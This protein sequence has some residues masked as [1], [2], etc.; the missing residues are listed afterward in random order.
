MGRELMRIGA[1][2][3]Q[4]EWSALALTEGP[5]RVVQAHR[6]FIEAGAQVITTNS[7]AIVPFH[8]SDDRF[9][10]EG[11]ELARTSSARR[12]QPHR[13]RGHS[14]RL[15][16]VMYRLPMA[17]TRSRILPIA[18]C[19]TFGLA[20]C[21]DDST[22]TTDD[23]TTP[24][25]APETIATSESETSATDATDTTVDDSSSG[26]EVV[27]KNEGGFLVDGAGM[28]LYIFAND[29]PDTSTCNTGCVDTWPPLLAGAS[30]FTL[31]GD[32]D[33]TDY[34][35]ATR[36]DGSSQIT[37]QGQPLYYYAGDSAP[38]D[39]NGDGIGGVWFTVDLS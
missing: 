34:N 29:P 9:R 33:P 32:L 2:F 19:F 11:R 18:I 28:T 16:D 39:T 23:V 27:L 25:S 21:G 31:Q 7:Y 24:A 5:Q 15:C 26:D 12:S 13:S 22:S 10:L 1:P 8:I 20:A 17:T 4:P 35:V 3:R 38:G 6:N 14:G 30:G 36:D 37:Y